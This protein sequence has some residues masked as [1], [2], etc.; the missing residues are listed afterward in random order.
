MKS[1]LF[2]ILILA[3]T[4][5][6]WPQQPESSQ[7]SGTEYDATPAAMAAQGVRRM[8]LDERAVA[9]YVTGGIG[10]TQMY[11]DNTEL[12]NNAQISDLSY[13]IEPHIALRY[14]TPRLSYD[15]AVTAGF[16][17]NRKLD[18]R[19][20]ATQNVAVDFSYHLSQFVVLRVNDSFR[21]TTGL[22][23]GPD[24]GGTSTVSTGVGPIQ[25]PNPSLLTYGRFRAN[26]VLAEL[27]GQ[28]TATS[29][30]GIRGEQSHTWFPGGATDPVIGQLFGGDT[31]TAEAF[32]N[33][34]FTLRNWGGLTLR[35]QRFNLNQSLGHTDAGSLLFMYAVSIRPTT[36]LSFFGGPQ[37]AVTSAAS[38]VTP[39]GGFQG[40]LWSPQ[41]GVV[42]NADTRSTSGT[43]SYTHGVSDGAGLVSAVTLDTAD[44]QIFRRLGHR[45]A[46]GP[47]FTYAES[48]PIVSGG[49]IRT[50][51]GRLQSTIQ[52]RACSFSLGYAHD[53]RSAVGSSAAAAANRIWI[54]F[55]YD[56]IRPIGR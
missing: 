18:N 21:N 32:Y 8:P 52:L 7:S 29:Y 23:T 37:L 48:T 33:H 49:K 44:A 26:T 30:A 15:A 34:R 53:D 41:A 13:D 17:L 2:L 39:Q 31:Y 9:N 35:A 24:I 16:V 47:G 40:R 3:V 28:F 38:S 27:S 6:A 1:L 56:F 25:Q 20:E 12:S 19:N 5:P 55:S 36:T 51:S 43:A 45:F 42:L 54:S 14:F 10:I 50:Y 4:I 22:W 11:T 46:I